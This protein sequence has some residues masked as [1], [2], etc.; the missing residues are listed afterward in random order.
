M[1]ATAAALDDAPSAV[2]YPRGEGVGLERP[3]RGQVLAIGKGRIVKEGSKVALI[4]LGTR[5][6]ECRKAAELLDARGISTTIADMRFAKPLDMEMIQRLANEHEAII[7]IEEGSIGG[8]GSHVVHHL[9][10]MGMM[11]RGLKVRVMT[12][13]DIFQDHD[14]PA[15]Q[16]DQ[17]GLTARHI[18]AKSMEALGMSESDIA[19]AA[20]SG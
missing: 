13:P 16:Y 1:V 4:N 18:V 15:K 11:D 9:A 17:A 19:A 12:L 5:L 8:F 7:T 10:N 6:T 20:V 3:A 14:A 2:R